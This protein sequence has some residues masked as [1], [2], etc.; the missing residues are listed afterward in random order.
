MFRPG[1]LR[2]EA[3][4]GAGQKMVQLPTG[5][6][7]DG[8][9]VVEL[10][11]R[12]V[13][14]LNPAAIGAGQPIE[15]LTPVRGFEVGDGTYASFAIDSLAV[16]PADPSV[17]GTATQ[18]FT[19]TATVDGGATVDVSSDVAWSSSDTGVAT[20]DGAGLATGVA[21]GTTTIT[22]TIGGVTATA[23]LTVT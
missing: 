22:A 18:Q 1:A 21:V 8:G 16:T 14:M 2:F 6:A 17:V 23:T 9:D 5:F 3:T 11:Q 15:T 4:I 19:A 12:Q 10:T 7:Y 13:E 20:I